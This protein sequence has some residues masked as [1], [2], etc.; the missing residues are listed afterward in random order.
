MVEVITMAMKMLIIYLLLGVA[1]IGTG[2]HYNIN[3]KNLKFDWHKLISGVL[4]LLIIGLSILL[5]TVCI[6]M[7]PAIFNEAGIEVSNIDDIT[8][9]IVFG[10]VA[11]GIATYALKFIENLRK[12]FKKEEEE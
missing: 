8:T 3:I 4:K 9:K 2:M 10:I 6:S 11:G 12:I 7:L 5:G 1:N